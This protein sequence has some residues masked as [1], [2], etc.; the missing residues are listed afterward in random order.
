MA[1]IVWTQAAQLNVR[2]IR[3]SIAH[4]SPSAAAGMVR[5]LRG[6]A[7]RL[8]QHPRSGW[9]VPEYANPA[10]REVIVAPYRIVYRFHPLRDEVQVV[11]VVHGSRLLPP[12]AEEE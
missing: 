5:R 8:A 3:R 7:A 9:T 2:E 11:A 6:E 10:L 1:E 4:D 12:L